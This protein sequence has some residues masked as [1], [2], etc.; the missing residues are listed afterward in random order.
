M[1]SQDI[2]TDAEITN[3]NLSNISDT[4]EKIDEKLGKLIEIMKL[5]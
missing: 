4:L 5:K 3:S 2:W 1:M